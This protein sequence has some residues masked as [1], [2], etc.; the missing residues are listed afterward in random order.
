MR[1]ALSALVLAACSPLEL[2]P[3]LELPTE[4]PVD[5]AVG[6]GAR[7]DAIEA[8]AL[9]IVKGEPIPGM[10]IAVVD[11]GEVVYAAGL[12]WADVEAERP[13]SAD[14]PVLLSSVSKSFVGVFA[15]QAVERGDLT[16]DTTA[17]DLIGFP[18]DNPR[19]D[20]ESVTLRHLLTHN[21]G[22]EDSGEY[23]A[24]YAEGD[25]TLDLFAFC[26]GY[27]TDG[28]AYWRGGNWSKRMPTEEFSYS[29]V[30]MACGAQAIG[31]HVGRPPRELVRDVLDPLGMTGTAYFLEDLSTEPAVPYSRA[32]ARVRAY[33]QYGYPTYPDGMLR[34][35]AV[36]L[37]RYVAAMGNRGELDG[38]R[39]LEE[40]TW[41]AMIEVDPAYG[42]DEEG[43]AIAWARREIGGRQ[44]IGHNGGDF[45]SL[46]EL[47]FDPE[48]GD[49]FAVAVNGFPESWSTVVAFE[50][51]LLAQVE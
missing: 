19:V 32:G 29:N 38:E 28:G 20:G 46:A 12:G 1:L 23:G 11:G 44:M 3:R 35:P 5:R 9:E 43:Q 22:L 37:G 49:G 7:A 17:A 48:T 40:G 45:G 41:E 18:V 34:S 14:T 31:T 33:A 51:A 13:L 21:S 25:P 39:V 16:L 36:D 47:W 2:G 42:T 8:L 6:E 15:M 10:A 4:V 50:E 27:L 24:H 26:E 30:G